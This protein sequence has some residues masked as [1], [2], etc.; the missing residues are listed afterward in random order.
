MGIAKRLDVRELANLTRAGRRVISLDEGN[1]I[2]RVR[3]TSGN[4]EL[5]FV[6][7]KGKALRTKEDEFR[8]LGRQARGV[9]AMRL[10]RGDVLV[11]CEPLRE[12]TLIL[13]ISEKGVGKRTRYDEFPLYHR[14][15]SGVKAMRLSNRTGLL[16]GAWSVTEDDE[17]MIVTSK[18]R[19]VR[20]AVEDV[21][22]LS[23]TAMGN[24]LVRLDR[25]DSVADVTI[26]REDAMEEV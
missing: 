8:P 20:I 26:I 25:G 21:P 11:G 16:V 9:R 13:L 19:V 22:V 4:D 24:I 23:R 17:V 3:F 2:A 14:G 10:S 1:I 7:A 12:G 5:L 18:G 15:S 6:S